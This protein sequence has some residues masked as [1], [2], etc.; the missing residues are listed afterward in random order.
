MKDCKKVQIHIK[1]KIINDIKH[2]IESLKYDDNDS[3]TKKLLSEQKSNNDGDEIYYINFLQKL[4]QSL[5]K[6]IES[7]KQKCKLCKEIGPLKRHISNL[8]RKNE[9]LI[10]KNNELN[11]KIINLKKRQSNNNQ[12]INENENEI[13]DIIKEN[14]KLQEIINK[15]RDEE[16][17]KIEISKSDQYIDIYFIVETIENKITCSKNQKFFEVEEKLYN[18]YPEYRKKDNFFLTNGEKI[19][20]FKTIEEN[21]IEDGSRI[22]LFFR[23]MDDIEDNKEDIL[24]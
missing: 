6:D 19:I 7:L 8:V 15:F 2:L 12:N 24:S 10:Q 18:I 4:F 11:N 13:S 23:D 1:K 20:E 9:Q 5:T 3:F 22:L 14:K 21:K 17:K 16:R